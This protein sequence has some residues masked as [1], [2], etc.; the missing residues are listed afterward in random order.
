MH[1]WIFINTKIKE[2]MHTKKYEKFYI[3]QELNLNLFLF[4]QNF[5]ILN[6]E[7]AL[8]DIIMSNFAY[9]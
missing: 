2:S 3:I 4:L 5:T 9:Q 6:N 1:G 7:S 8:I